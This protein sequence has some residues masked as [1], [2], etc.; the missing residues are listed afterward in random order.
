MPMF[1]M[2]AFLCFIQNF[3]INL[4]LFSIQPPTSIGDKFTFDFD[5]I[6]FIIQMFH[7]IFP[8]NFHQVSCFYITIFRA[9]SH[10]W[11]RFG[12]SIS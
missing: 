8:F 4:S 2:G 9:V 10:K 6:A 5:I 7:Y 11:N 1:S 3:I 12:H